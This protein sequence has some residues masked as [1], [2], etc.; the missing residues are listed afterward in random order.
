MQTTVTKKSPFL[1]SIEVKESGAEFEKAQKL[2]IEDF[3]KNGKING[4]KP[5]TAPD[6]VIIKQFGQSAIDQH[7]VDIIID[8]IYP[9]ILKKENIIPVAPGNI[10]ELKSTNPLEFVIEVEI[11]PEVT[12]DEKKL[13][14]IKVKK[15]NFKVMKKE[16]DEEI[17]AIKRRFTHYHEAGV[18]ADDG[19]DTSHTAIENGDRATITAQGY[20]KKGGDAIPETAVPS[21]PLVIGSG[22]FI[23]GFEEKLIGAKAGDEVAFD[24]TF[25]A[26]YHSEEFKGRKV[27]F[28]VN[29]EK[30]EKPHAPE[31]TEDFIEKL[32]GV[33]TDLEGFKEIIKKE[34]SARKET[35]NRRKDEDTLMKKMLEA[36]TIEVGPALVANEVNQ[37]FAEHSENLAQQGLNMK[38][39]LEHI[40]MDEEAYKETVVK[41]EAERRLKAELL[42]RKIREIR[43]VEATEAEIKEELEKIIAQYQNAEV[44]ARLREK[45]VPGDMYYEDI[46]NRLAYRKT[47]DMFWE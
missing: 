29:V 44:V 28:V 37:I 47:V 46:K 11:F 13:D 25:P 27:H 34:I 14:A 43:K 45:L 24:I 30:V 42:L 40:K 6:N 20:D 5:G 36:A 35:E 1:L 33:K 18:H 10:T 32:R 41:P 19:A 38:Q 12:I 3:R 39:Y 8:K 22:N 16:I 31:F 7:A 26:D 17:E 9:K 23:P 2:A 21:Y 4:F 15:T